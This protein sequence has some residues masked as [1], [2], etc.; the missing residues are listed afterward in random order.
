[1]IPGIR[2]MGGIAGIRGIGGIAGAAG[3]ADGAGA[4]VPC[5][6][7]GGNRVFVA[8]GGLVSAVDGGGGCRVG[9]A[10]WPVPGGSVAAGGCELPPVA[11]GAGEAGVVFTPGVGVV[12][13]L[14][15]EPNPIASAVPTSRSA[16]TAPMITTAGNRRQGMTEFLGSAGGRSA[17]SNFSA[18]RVDVWPGPPGCGYS[19][20]AMGTTRE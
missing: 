7:A 18:G 19:P 2:G 20:V 3:T 4:T 15:L 9:A 13:G 16:T 5:W 12:A 14:S 17:C 1:M 11:G 8:A 10:G 6:V